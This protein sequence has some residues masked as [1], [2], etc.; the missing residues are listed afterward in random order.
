M[1]NL[2][3]HKINGVLINLKF[4][5]LALINVPRYF[6]VLSYVILD[7]EDSSTGHR[8]MSYGTI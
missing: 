3:K 6:R 8:L 1:R 2:S 7:S 4:F 5:P